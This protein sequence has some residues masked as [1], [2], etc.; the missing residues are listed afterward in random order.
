MDFCQGESRGKK[1]ELYCVRERRGE[2]KTRSFHSSL[3]FLKTIPAFA[4]AKIDYFPYF[5]GKRLIHDFIH[6]FPE[7]EPRLKAFGKYFQMEY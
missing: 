2:K 1:K 6:S 5:F 7:S 4:T 3:E